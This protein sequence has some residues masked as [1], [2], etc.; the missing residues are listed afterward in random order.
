M[1][2]PQIVVLAERVEYTY[3]VAVIFIG[4]ENNRPAACHCQ[5]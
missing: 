2:T 4:G 3:I 1:T 5:T